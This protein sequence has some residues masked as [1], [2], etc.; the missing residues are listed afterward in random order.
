MV[1]IPKARNTFCKKCNG[2]SKH[3]VSQ[4]KQSKPNPNAQGARRYNIKQ[5]GYG[6]Q[7]KP[8]FRRKAKVTKKLVLKLECTSCKSVHQKTL[9]PTVMCISHR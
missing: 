3:K 1:N 4:Y 8:I 6:V 9:F 2:Y 7:T 5:M